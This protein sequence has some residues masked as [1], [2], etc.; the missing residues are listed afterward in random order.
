MEELKQII[1]KGKFKIQMIK[2]KPKVKDF[3]GTTRT[4]ILITDRKVY[5]LGLK[6]EVEKIF[7][8]LLKDVYGDLWFKDYPNNYFKTYI[9]KSYD[10][11]TI[12]NKQTEIKKKPYYSKMRILRK[13]KP[14]IILLDIKMEPIDG[15]ETLKRI[16]EIDKNVKVI[17][18][19]ALED[20]DNM[21][22]ASKLGV[23][24]YIA[25]PLVLEELET[26]VLSHTRG[27]YD[28]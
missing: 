12:K 8:K 23:L 28:A 2:F 9:K 11:Q 17:M 25:K 15:I 27:D 24:Q 20:R 16:R 7:R 18:V 26:A 1:K 13:E 10:R 5:F 21:E 3:L 14:H 19:T 4:Y 22:A 6:S